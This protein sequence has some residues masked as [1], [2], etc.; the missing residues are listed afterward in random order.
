M[1]GD[2]FTSIMDL[3]E[4]HKV[5]NINELPGVYQLRIDERWHLAINGKESEIEVELEKSMPVKI[6]P[7]NFCVWHNGW[8]AGLFDPIN[9]G[10]F[11]A[12][13][14]VNEEEFCRAIEEYIDKEE[15]K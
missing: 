7:Y 2:A 14:V 10:F 4:F 13:D 6:P 3:L 8:L 9:G 1:K 11:A 5:S 15:K 12:G